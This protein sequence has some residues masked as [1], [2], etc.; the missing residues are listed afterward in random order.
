[1]KHTKKY[2]IVVAALLVILLLTY[3]SAT[4]KTDIDSSKVLISVSS[5]LWRGIAANVSYKIEQE[6]S[7]IIQGRLQVDEAGG[8]HLV[9]TYE[10]LT[11]AAKRYEQWGANGAAMAE[12]LLAVYPEDW[13][14]DHCILVLA[15]I[16]ED[17]KMMV[18]RADFADGQVTL[19]LILC[20]DWLSVTDDMRTSHQMILI[21]LPR[22]SDGI[23]SVVFK[24]SDMPKRFDDSGPKLRAGW[25]TQQELFPNQRLSD[26]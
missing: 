22:P 5:D 20:D 6:K 11:R 9:N 1:M 25:A 19:S 17:L 4:R 3:C 14:Q 26:K 18:Q 23:R 24:V 7:R 2:G 10:E 13:F 8:V 21:G 12:T 15:Q 16:S